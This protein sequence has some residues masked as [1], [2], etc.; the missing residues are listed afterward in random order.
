MVSYVSKMV[1]KESDK[2]NN[3]WKT[4]IK[5]KNGNTLTTLTEICFF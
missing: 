2:N 3:K 1:V 5:N 4:F